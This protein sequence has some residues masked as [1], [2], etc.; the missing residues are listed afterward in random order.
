[1]IRNNLKGFKV[2]IVIHF[3]L[4][5]KKTQRLKA[6]TTRS[7]NAALIMWLLIWSLPN[8][9]LSRLHRLHWSHPRNPH[10]DH[11]RRV[12]HLA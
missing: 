8:L 2:I 9:F 4:K 1:M 10:Y 5:L 7:L 11:L 6:T 3:K 12:S